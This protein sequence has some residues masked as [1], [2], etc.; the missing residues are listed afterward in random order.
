MHFLKN[1]FDGQAKMDMLSQRK[2]LSQK[3]HT[4]FYLVT[5]NL[6]LEWV[7]YLNFKIIVFPL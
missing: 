5:G 3:Q 2:M 7:A 4:I 1:I 6:Y